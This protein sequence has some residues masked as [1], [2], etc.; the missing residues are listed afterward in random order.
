M[1]Y[2]GRCFLSRY[3]VGEKASANLG[4]CSQP[5]RREYS[6]ESERTNEDGEKEVILMEDEHGSYF[7]NSHDLCCIE[8]I[9]ELMEAGVTSFKVEGRTK[10]I[11]YVSMVM[12]AYREVIDSVSNGTYNPEDIAY[13]KNEMNKLINRGYSTGFMF[14]EAIRDPSLDDAM[15]AASDYRFVGEYMEDGT[16]FVHNKICVGDALEIIPVHGRSQVHTIQKIIKNGEELQEFSA[17]NSE[18]YITLI[19]D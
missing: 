6:Y 1:A 10:S 9:R 16:V 13:W 19:L 2:S 17:G 18:S 12:K 8:Y 7:F 5:C 3:F 11:F 15:S 14:G 4:A